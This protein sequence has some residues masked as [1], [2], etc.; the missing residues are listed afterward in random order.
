MFPSFE[1]NELLTSREDEPVADP[2]QDPCG[3]HDLQGHCRCQHGPREDRQ[4]PRHQ[5]EL[6]HAKPVNQVTADPRPKDRAQEEQTGYRQ[7]ETITG[8]AFGNV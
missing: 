5:A 6:L 3:Q 1:H 4:R 2:G 8:Y 7:R